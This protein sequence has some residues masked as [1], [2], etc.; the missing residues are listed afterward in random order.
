M[1]C[2]CIGIAGGSGSGKTT[3]ARRLLEHLPNEVAQILGQDNYYRDQSHKFDKDG[4]AVNFD[5]PDALELDLLASQIDQLKSGQHVHVPM[6]DFVSHTRLTKTILVEPPKILLVDG[7]L[8]YSNDNICNVLDEMVFIEVEESIR[9]ERRLKRDTEER[10]R[11]PEGVQEQ[12]IK[13]VKPMHD[14]FVEPSKHRASHIVKVHEF[15]HKVVELA[16]LLKRFLM[17]L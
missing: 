4:G 8:I 13:Q 3:F 12:F 11:T 1:K 15:D 9:Y 5:H 2:Y 6:Y 16:D 10:G 14:Q 7:T 17:S